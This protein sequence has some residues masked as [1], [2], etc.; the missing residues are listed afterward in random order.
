MWWGFLCFSPM[1]TL[2]TKEFK[3][4]PLTEFKATSEG[5]GGFSG[6]PS[7]FY[8]LDTYGDIILPGAYTETISQFLERGFVGHSHEWEMAEVVGFPVLAREDGIGLYSEAM[9]HSTQNAQ[10]CRTI[11]AERMAANKFVGL[12]IGFYTLAAEDIASD[13]YDSE[14]PKFIPPEKLSL[15][16]PEIRKLSW[17]RLVKKIELFEYSIVTMPAMQSAGIVGVRGL[18]GRA[19]DAMPFQDHLRLVTD[20][21]GDVVRRTAARHDLLTREGRKLSAATI[22]HLKETHSH[23]TEACGKL[24]NLLAEVEQPE[25]EGKSLDMAVLRA[26]FS[27]LENH[28]RLR[29]LTQ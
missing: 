15:L 7:K 10:T 17:V 11:A 19:T 5:A 16:M 2:E 12:S 25:D 23:M 13:A 4:A 8:E 28:A 27:Q 22:A 1:P 24:G 29:Q 20:A 3:V 9:Y 21:T 26:R 18:S 6:Y 14:L